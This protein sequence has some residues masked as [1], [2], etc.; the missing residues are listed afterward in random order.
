M[1]PGWLYPLQ[2][3][4]LAFKQAVALHKVYPKSVKIDDYV[5]RK[6]I[7]QLE[8]LRPIGIIQ[9]IDEIGEALSPD[10][11]SPPSKLEMLQSVANPSNL[12][13]AIEDNE[14][15]LAARRVL[16]PREVA[17]QIL[18]DVEDLICAMKFLESSFYRCST[19]L[20]TLDE[21]YYH[22]IVFD[23]LRQNPY[24]SLVHFSVCSEAR[25]FL[26]FPGSVRT[27]ITELFSRAYFSRDVRELEQ[28]SLEEFAHILRDK[29]PLVNWGHVV[30]NSI[31]SSQ[32]TAEIIRGLIDCLFLLEEEKFRETSSRKTQNRR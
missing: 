22:C 18:K 23:H 29:K 5:A 15:E 27:L 30:T 20:L 16:E 9:R 3:R 7:D 14:R 6:I 10:T 19:N 11:P 32:E 13:E 28:L 1:K 2:T 4:L 25:R 8:A 26:L 31:E 21:K 17:R 24:E 12:M